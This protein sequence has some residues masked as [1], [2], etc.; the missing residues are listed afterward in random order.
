VY[1]Y[2]LRKNTLLAVCL[3]Q[4]ALMRGEGVSLFSLVKRS[5]QASMLPLL[6]QLAL[7][8]ALPS[9]IVLVGVRNALLRW[10]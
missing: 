9:G 4:F 2:A 7:V 1:E 10:L 8:G 3:E 6:Q 5:K